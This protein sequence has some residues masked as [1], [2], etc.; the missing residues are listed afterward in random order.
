NSFGNRKGGYPGVREITYK[1]EEVIVPP[2]LPDT[3]ETQEELA[4]YYQSVSRLDQ[5]IGRLIEILKQAGKYDN[6]LI[7][8]I[9]DNGMA[10][11]AAKTTLYEAGVRLPCIIKAPNQM[12]GFVQE[13]LISWTDI[14]PTILDYARVSVDRE[15]IYGRSF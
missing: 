7:I 9:S 11:P 12:A 5:G 8:Y 13:G 4:Q 10:F 6:T 15:K 2:F 14:T 3:K 1:P